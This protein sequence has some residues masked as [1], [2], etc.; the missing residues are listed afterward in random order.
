MKKI[1]R[2]TLEK[3]KEESGDFD[4]SFYLVN[5]LLDEYGENKL[6]SL[7]YREIDKSIDWN[8]IADLFNILIWST[9]DN[10]SQLIRETNKWLIEAEDI[11]KIKIAL[12]L[13]VY[14]FKEQD[15]MERVLNDIKSKYP[16]LAGKCN[17]LIES[18]QN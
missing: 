2:Q 5:C 4:E 15:K 16:N 12:N 6:A 9:S 11:R 14:P 13:D 3:I 8:V 17:S 1:L 18:R 10:G 7:L